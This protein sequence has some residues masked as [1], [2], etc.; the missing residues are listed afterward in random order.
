MTEVYIDDIAQ[1][2]KNAG[3]KD[4][5]SVIFHSS[6][7]SMGHVKGGAT[8]VIDGVLKAVGE[9]GTVIVPTLWW[10]G[11]GKSAENFDIATSPAYN[12]AIPEAMR[13]DPRSLRSNHF[14]HSVN[15]IGARA[16]ELTAI[17][18]GGKLYPDPWC[19]TAFS[20]LSPWTKLYEWDTLYAF[21]GC[22]MLVCTMKHWVEGH[23][24]Q[25]NLELLP[26]EIRLE[27]RKKL[28]YHRNYTAWNNFDIEAMQEILAQD[29]LVAETK[30]GDA[31][32]IAIRTRAF[33]KRAFELLYA[34]PEK[35]FT[36]EFYAWYCEVRKIAGK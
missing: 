16:A 14:S 8:A 6:L 13:Q 25:E 4:G 3:A 35:W 34:D 23:F 2:F 5:D 24:I 20:E 31:K 1:A 29:G 12:G 27:Y 9:K 36:P 26:S 11:K 19:E 18:G 15:A 10:S 17:H 21:I 22:T 30:L 32:L 33:V 7:K 28:H